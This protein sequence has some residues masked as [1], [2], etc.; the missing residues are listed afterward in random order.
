MQ[1]HATP[2]RRK[3]VKIFAK[4]AHKYTLFLSFSIACFL[5]GNEF[6]H[7]NKVKKMQL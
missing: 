7:M 5:L 1:M 3:F 4:D 6:T 2:D